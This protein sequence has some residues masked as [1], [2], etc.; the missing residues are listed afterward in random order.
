MYFCRLH[1]KFNGMKKVAFI[2]NSF[3]AGGAERIT[4]D[5]ARFLCSTGEYDKTVV[6]A[7]H[8]NTSLFPNS[9][10]SHH[11]FE[12]NSSVN[13]LQYDNFIEVR[14]I[15]SQAFARKRAKAVEEYV[16]ED[17]VDVLVQVGKKLAGIEGVKART[18]CK[19]VLASH[20]EVFWQRY[21]IMHRRQSRK[22]L[23]ELAYK[24]K[25]G[26]GTKAMAMAVARSWDEYKSCDAYTVLCEAYKRELEAAFDRLGN[27]TQSHVWAIENPERVVEEPTLEKEKLILFCGRMENWSKRID[28]FLRIWAKVQDKMPS[29]RVELVGDGPD[30]ESLERLSKELSL[31]RL[32]FKG[33]DSNVSA[34]YRRASVVVMTSQTE[35]WPLALSE[36]QAHGCIGVAFNCSAGVEEILSS[37]GFLVEAFNEDEYATILLQIASMKEDDLSRIRIN[38]INKRKQYAPELIASKWKRLFDSLCNESI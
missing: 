6:Y 32:E 36:G 31:E 1:L 9:D 3:P 38:S 2:H 8:I 12:N 34:Y 27:G 33:F 26:D 4:I 16:L 20:G 35:G 21:A 7:T 22:L 14:Y 30:K 37:C 25:Y 23:W 10:N 24:K 15:P 28:R 17:G 18:G 19:V 29:W 11:I 5:I 13:R